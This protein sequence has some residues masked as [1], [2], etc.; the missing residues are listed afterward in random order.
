MTLQSI[1]LNRLVHAKTNVR[2]TGRDLGI[3]G[4]MV[5]IGTHGL[6]QNLNVRP[7]SGNR[8]EVV[9]GGRRLEAMRRLAKAGKMAAAA[10]VLCQVLGEGDNPVEISLVENAHRSDMHPDDECNAFAE[11]VEGGMAPEDIGARFGVSEVVVRRRLRLARVSPKLRKLHRDGDVS[12]AQMMA[13]ALVDDHAAQEQAW[14]SLPDYHR[15][16]R[17]LRRC[18]TQE[19]VSANHRLV[20]FVGVEAYEEAGG[21]VLRD[22]FEDEPP[23]LADA[24][25]VERLAIDKLEAAAKLVRAEGWVWVK[26]ALQN[27]YEPYDRIYPA[28][29]DDAYELADFERAGAKVTLSYDGTIQIERGLVERA[30]PVKEKRS[31]DANGTP[32]YSEAVLTDL[33]AHKSAAM[34]LELA[35]RPKVALAAVVHAMGLGLLY[36]TGVGTCLDLSA[37]SSNLEARVQ[38]L[39]ECSAHAALGET[40][41][42]WR[43]SLPTDTD[44]F[45]AWCLEAD[46]EKL[47]E[48]L[49]L[50]AG[51]TIDASHNKGAAAALGEAL[52]LDMRKH[53]APKVDGFFGRLSKPLMEHLLTEAGEEVEAATLAGMKKGEAAAKTAA[54]LTVR[55][56]LPAVLV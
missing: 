28:N 15:D 37:R 36:H 20:R 54:L 52:G 30:E 53:W 50:L 32:T 40:I 39:D 4:L 7:T 1:P 14:T 45:W 19:G 42:A 35:Q 31:T 48:L 26:V 10:P 29:E 13:L 41:A 23:V 33:T 43:E 2:K 18:L 55:E 8:F 24:M 47:S 27:D 49:A 9:A 25:L 38:L 11:L 56:W 16:P 44:G 46:T 3:E 21:V 17:S 22:L 34:R 6:R 51:L 5:S 12:L